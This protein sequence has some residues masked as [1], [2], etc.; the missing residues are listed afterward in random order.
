MG[1][2]AWFGGLGYNN[3]VFIHQYLII[4]IF[5]YSGSDLFQIQRAVALGVAY[6]ERSSLGNKARTPQPLTATT[7]KTWCPPLPAS[8]VFSLNIVINQFKSKVTSPSISSSYCMNT[9]RNYGYIINC[10]CGSEVSHITEIILNKLGLNGYI[11]DE[12]G[13]LP[14]LK[15]LVL[16]DNNL[17]GSI[18]FSLGSLLHL[19]TLDL[20]NNQLTGT[21]PSSLGDLSSLKWLYLHYNYLE[22][23]I[24]STLGKLSSLQDLYLDFNMLS[25]SIPDELG[26]LYNL[27]KLHLAENRLSGSLPTTL[28]NLIN[29]IS[30]E[31]SGNELSGPLPN[32]KNW[33]KIEYISVQGNNFEGEVPAEYF[34]LSSLQYLFIS[35]LHNSH[36]FK[37]PHSANV[38]NLYGLVLR[39]CSITGSIPEFIGQISSLIH[40]DLSYNTLTGTIPESMKSNMIYMDLSYNNFSEIDIPVPDLD[41]NLFACCCCQS[42]KT[43]EPYMLQPPEMMKANFPGKKP[44]FYNL[45]INCGGEETYFNGTRYDADNETTRFHSISSKRNWA[46]SFSGDF[47]TPTVNTS[48][49]YTKRVPCKIS[50]SQS[51][52]YESARLSPVSLNYYAYKLYKGKY[53]VTF[54]F[55]EIVFSKDYDR[56]RKRVFDVYIQGKRELR[57]FNIRDQAGASDR[58]FNV[59]IPTEVNN[60]IMHIHM[61]W[62]G[63]GSWVNAPNFNGPLISAISIIP[64]FPVGGEKLSPWLVA[65]ITVASFVIVLLLL[66]TIAWLMGW[67]DDEELKEEIQVG[68]NIDEGKSG[69][70][71]RTTDQATEDKDEIK[72]E[73][74]IDKDQHH[75]I[76]VAVK[77]L[78]HRYKGKINEIV[79]GEIY[80]LKSLEDK[81]L[82]R[83]WDAHIGEHQQLLVYEYMEKRSLASVLFDSD[84]SE[85]SW[86]DRFDI[87]KGIAMGLKALHKRPRGKIVHGNIKTANILLNEHYQAKL[88][89][90]GLA[91][92]YSEEDQF[93]VIKA[94]TTKG[95]LAPEYFQLSEPTTETDIY[96]FG[97]VF[98]EIVC[99]QQNKVR[100]SKQE[101]VFLLDEVHS[102]REE[103]LLKLVDKSLEGEFKD[104]E[105]SNILKLA[106]MCTDIA[107]TVRPDIADIVSVLSGKK[108]INEIRSQSLKAS[109]DVG[110]DASTSME[111]C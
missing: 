69:S 52:I 93:S 47:F 68:E 19:E 29:L 38:S 89:D 74:N 94:E 18:P 21:I 20:S 98:L 41:L 90:F 99:G 60:S 95:Y 67:L 77:K 81:N 87:C 57:D 65:L 4:I 61:Y 79:K 45:F 22:G 35:D 10:E 110:A 46:F 80:N 30:F 37:L 34:N 75:N 83:L 76:T 1:N 8:E 104:R 13:N 109:N 2:K 62:A 32:V 84:K 14:W 96:S 111:K 36:P 15:K 23:S 103:K 49:Y 6:P 73:M 40:L 24:P 44:K 58:A 25:G 17:Q 59:T 42:S 26:S 7:V 27:L 101:T 9:L 72:A 56:L 92:V 11:D 105:A 66:L 63:K 85:L 39:N 43:T 88:S 107:P 50:N 91:K 70:T 97:V 53:N 86:K 108:T 3:K 28:A 106:K 82:I 71:T 31:V 5:L 78:S 48:D 16:S 64:D 54:H 51:S 100:K 55:A 12:V 102:Y 33:S